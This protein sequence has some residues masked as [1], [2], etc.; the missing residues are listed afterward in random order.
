MRD[1]GV[2]G[3]AAELLGKST[4]DGVVDKAGERALLK[5]LWRELLRELLVKLLK[6]F[7]V[8]TALHNASL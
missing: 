3:A 4:F 5:E 7:D 1:T 8:R 2:D 6:R